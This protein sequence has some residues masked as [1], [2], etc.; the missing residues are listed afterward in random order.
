M[1]RLIPVQSIYIKQ[2]LL[3]MFIFISKCV[4]TSDLILYCSWML[5]LVFEILEMFLKR[6]NSLPKL[7]IDTRKYTNPC[8][9]GHLTASPGLLKLCLSSFCFLLQMVQDALFL[10]ALCQNNEF[11]CKS[12]CILYQCLNFPLV[13]P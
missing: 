4:N 8:S 5:P 9:G 2:A 11:I 10:H 13:L 6:L 12:R 3:K 1:E 7:R